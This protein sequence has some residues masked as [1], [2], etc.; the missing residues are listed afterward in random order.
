M[1][2]TFVRRTTDVE[3]TADMIELAYLLAFANQKCR[4]LLVWR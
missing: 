4:S 2:G 1:N 3:K